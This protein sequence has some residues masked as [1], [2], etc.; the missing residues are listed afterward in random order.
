MGMASR[1]TRQVLTCRCERSGRSGVRA[2]ACGSAWQRALLLLPALRPPTSRRPAAL[3]SGNIFEGDWKE[4]KPQLKD[5]K[6]KGLADLLPWL[7][8]QVRH[9]SHGPRLAAKGFGSRRSPP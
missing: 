1:P 6:S 2:A 4:G 7:N 3:P 9:C 8:E 5:N